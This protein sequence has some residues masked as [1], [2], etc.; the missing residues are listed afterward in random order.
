MFE[1]ASR[2]FAADL[3]FLIFNLTNNDKFQKNKYKEKNKTSIFMEE[4]LRKENPANN[5]KIKNKI[6]KTSFKILA[7]LNNGKFSKNTMEYRPCT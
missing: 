5:K 3:G 4:W 7:N 6:K 2:M 1:T